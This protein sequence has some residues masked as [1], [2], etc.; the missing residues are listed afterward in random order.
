MSAGFAGQIDYYCGMKVLM[1]CLGNICRSPLAEGILQSKIRE[2]GLNW[3]VDSAGT[4]AWH[5]GEKP[6]RRSIK[7]AQHNGIDITYQRARQF[8][9]QDL[10][11]YD[12][13]FAMDQSNRSN[14][15]RLAQSPDQISKVHLI[16][17]L[18]EPQ[19]DINVPDPYY[20]DNGFNQVFEML[21]E[22]CE[23]IIERW[24]VG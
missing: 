2:K 7:V 22:A 23:R 13:V 21:D 12:L 20:D 19:A 5:V 14:I 17:N 15:L 10:A 3:E 24:Q 9:A 11:E 18:V 6:D 16:M 1:V 8:R 4:G